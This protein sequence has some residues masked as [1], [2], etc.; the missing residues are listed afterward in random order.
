MLIPGDTHA[1]LV[2]CCPA[3]PLPPGCA[4]AALH[5]TAELQLHWIQQEKE[6]NNT[7]CC[8]P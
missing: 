2:Q 6:G 1:S 7:A 8:L 3:E 4:A 5:P